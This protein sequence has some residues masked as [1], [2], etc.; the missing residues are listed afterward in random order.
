MW[1]IQSQTHCEFESFING[2]FI[3]YI[4]SQLRKFEAR[5]CLLESGQQWKRQ[6]VVEWFSTVDEVSPT[7]EHIIA[8]PETLESI[9]RFADICLH[10]AGYD[11][12]SFT[13]GD[14]IND[15]KHFYFSKISVAK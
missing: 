5:E 12:L 11:M 9:Y 7:V 13:P 14:I 4:S 1:L 6:S 2:D 8:C 10:T 3:L 15:R